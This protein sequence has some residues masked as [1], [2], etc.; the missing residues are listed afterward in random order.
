[1]LIPAEFITRWIKSKPGAYV[2]VVIDSTKA[3]LTDANGSMVTQAIDGHYPDY[4]SLFPDDDDN[5][6]GGD[7]AYTPKY[8]GDIFKAAALFAPRG[9]AP[10]RVRRMVT[11]KPAMFTVALPDATLRMLLMPARVP[12]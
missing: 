8:M 2:T 3:T 7:V 10:V 5:S 6:T 12:V 1:M 9:E 4:K 11:G